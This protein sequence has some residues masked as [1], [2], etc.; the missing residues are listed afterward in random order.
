MDVS[1]LYHTLRWLRGEQILAQLR[2][3]LWTPLE[4][5]ESLLGRPVPPFPGCAWQPRGELVPPGAQRNREGA[6]LAGSFEFLNRSRSLGFP[7][8]WSNPDAGK[9]WE[10]NLHYFEWLWALPFEAGCAAARDW[11]RQHGPARGRVGWEPYPISLR[12]LNWCAW[13]FG[14][15]RAA[16]LADPRLAEELW[17]SVAR[18]ADWLA[19]HL[20]RHLMGN[21]LFENAAALAACGACFAGEAARGWRRVGVDLLAAELADQV[22]P[23]GGHVERSPMYQARLAWVLAALAWTGDPELVRCVE[24]P[25]ARLLAALD[26]LRHP[27]GEIALLND[28]AFGI[29]NPPGELS[30]AA[31][32]LGPFALPDTGYFGARTAAG[33][34]VVC[35]AAPIGPDHVPGHGHGDLLGFE[36]SLAGRRVLVDTGV[37]D[38]EPGELRAV[39]RSTRAHNTVELDGQDQCEFWAAFRVARRG[40]PRDVAFEPIGGGF[41]LDAWHDGYERLPARARHRRWFRFHPEGVLLVRDRVSADREVEACSRLHLHPDCEVVELSGSLARLR[42]PGGSFAVRFAGAGE[43]SLEPCV[44]FPE[45][46]RRQDNRALAFRARGAS[47]Y[48]GFCVAHAASRL[49]YDLASGARVDGAVFAV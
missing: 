14:R 18:Q 12:L 26:R 37:H 35:D 38:Y 3:R 31:P 9:L 30:D 8:R 2:H 11:I 17:G 23:D 41:R 1:R 46:G 45:F 25:R 13:F 34:Y 43:L 33:H 10:Y 48:T 5:P 36:L 7:P 22:L 29:A 4:R 39:S 40:R 21:H 20:E 16:T 19:A 28:S 24:A 49:D 32:P 6:L 42:H 15:H 27:D 44:W 47:L